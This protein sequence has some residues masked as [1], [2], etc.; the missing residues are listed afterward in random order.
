MTRYAH[1]L[2]GTAALF[3][4]IVG[5]GLLFLRPWLGA[6]I[7]FDPATGTN[8]VFVNFTGALVALFGFGY[9]RVALNPLRYRPFIPFSIAGKS[10]AVLCT[11]YAWSV[12]AIAWRLPAL[13]SADIVFA[14]LYFDFFRRTE[15]G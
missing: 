7:H 2:F 6:L 9:A 12:G 8:L 5:L 1:W 14:L 13:V 11:F 4:F 10:L 15:A 3:N